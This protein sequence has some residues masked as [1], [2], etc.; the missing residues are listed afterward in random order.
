MADAFEII[1]E[2]ECRAHELHLKEWNTWFASEEFA[3]SEF[4]LTQWTIDMP[5]FHWIIKQ[6]NSIDGFCPLHDDC[7]DVLPA[8]NK[9][10]NSKPKSHFFF[11]F[12]EFRLQSSPEMAGKRDNLKEFDLFDYR[13][14]TQTD[15]WY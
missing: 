11:E 6:W 7:N 12:D 13:F 9:L 8:F 3:L 10:S 2:T 4:K 15:N 14:N 1:E 5:I